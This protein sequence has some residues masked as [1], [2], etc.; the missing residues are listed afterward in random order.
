MNEMILAGLP[1]EY[2]QLAVHAA[3]GDDYQTA[4]AALTERLEQ[5]AGGGLK[6]QANVEKVRDELRQ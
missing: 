1:N 3:Q 5:A 6:W 4:L 2:Q